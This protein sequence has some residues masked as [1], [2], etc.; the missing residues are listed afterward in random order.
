MS[1]FV[2]VHGGWRGGWIWKTVARQLR[3]EGNDVYTPTLTG[4]ADRKH[5]LHSDINLSTHIQEIVSLIEYEELNDVVLLRSLLRRHGH[6]VYFECLTPYGSH[7]HPKVVMVHGGNHTGSCY[8]NTL[9]D[10]PG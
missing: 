2:L 4:L 8:L 3:K 5:L 7:Q 10:K 6:A 1:N 9:E